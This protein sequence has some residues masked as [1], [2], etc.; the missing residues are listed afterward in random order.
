LH[1]IQL[2]SDLLRHKLVRP[3][4]N[5]QRTFEDINTFPERAT[6]SQTRGDIDFPLL[7][8]LC[9]ISTGQSGD[10]GQQQLPLLVAGLIVQLHRQRADRA[11]EAVWHVLDGIDGLVREVGRDDGRLV[12]AGSPILAGEHV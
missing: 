1:S 10:K 12:D 5:G 8:N 9:R 11:R 2:N 3:P 7:L 6:V 4:A